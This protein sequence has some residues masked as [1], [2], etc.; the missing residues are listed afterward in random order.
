MSGRSPCRSRPRPMRARRCD[1]TG[2][3]R[4]EARAAL[5]AMPSHRVA[6]PP[7]PAAATP[8][9][10][11]APEYWFDS[12]HVPALWQSGADGRGITI[13]E[14]D[15]GVNAALPELTGRILPGID[16]GAGGNGQIDREIEPFGH[17]TAMA[18][19]MVARSGLFG[20][21]GHRAG[22][23]DPSGRGPAH[24]HRRR[25]RQRPPR[26]RD[27][28]GRRPRRPRSSACRSAGTA[29]C[30]TATPYPA[31]T[32]SSRRSTTRCARARPAGRGRQ[33]RAGSQRG[34]GAGRLPGRGLGRGGRRD[35]YRRR[36]LVPAPVPD[37]DRA[38]RQ[39]PVAGPRWPARRTPATGPARPP[40]WRRP[41]SRWSGRSTRT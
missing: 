17:G 3:T 25:R 1:L 27:Q 28:V 16:Y 11:H 5:L 33:Q 35:R 2:A 30:P 36:L 37:D 9:P 41:P 12:W 23:Q 31:R 32:T 13:A 20:I 24:R 22:R 19:I 40:R 7:P 4:R 21:E 6:A 15:T 29:T 14:I 8:G 39:H 34:R 38:R 10:A 18:S 26:R